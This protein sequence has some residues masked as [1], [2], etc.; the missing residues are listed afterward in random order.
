[1][2]N[3]PA[4]MITISEKDYP[5]EVDDWG[6]WI[7]PSLAVEAPTRDGLEEKAKRAAAK[8]KVKVEVPFT[9]FRQRHFGGPAIF[10]DYTA[11]G[12]HGG[13][14]NVMMRDDKTGKSL[15]F[16]SYDHGKALRR[17]TDEEKQ[18]GH[19]LLEAHTAAKR[20]WD[21]WLSDHSLNL[22]AEVT[23]AVERK[24]SES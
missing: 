22:A 8:A 11:S 1:M 14:G 15:Q 16:L 3:Y 24:M 17:L 5:I 7:C 4:G 21:T 13:T 19:H 20:A 6:R 18:E 23:W 9:A 2:S 10:A 12:V